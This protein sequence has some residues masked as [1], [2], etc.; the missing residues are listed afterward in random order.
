[1]SE[2][3]IFV[4]GMSCNHCKMNVENHLK[5]VAGVKDIN[6][7]LDSGIVTINGEKVDLEKVKETVESIGYS[8][9]D[10]VA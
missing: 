3:K 10:E 2:I 7:D 6:A 4:R 9:D 5:L 1:M 8:Y